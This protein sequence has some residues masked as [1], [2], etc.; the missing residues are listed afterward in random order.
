MFRLGRHHCSVAK[1]IFVR[2]SAARRLGGTATGQPR[3]RN[4]HERQT[5]GGVSYNGFVFPNGRYRFSGFSKPSASSDAHR[6]PCKMKRAILAAV[7]VVW[8]CSP[9]LGKDWVLSQRLGFRLGTRIRTH[10]R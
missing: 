8:G 3:S 4:Y 6:G 2:S 7:L 10:A 9:T 5:K 1:A